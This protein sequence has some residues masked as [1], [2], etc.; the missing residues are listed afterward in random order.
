MCVSDADG[1]ESAGWHRLLLPASGAKEVIELPFPAAGIRDHVDPLRRSLSRPEG[2]HH[3]LQRRRKAILLVGA[4]RPGPQCAG[5]GILVD[6]HEILVVGRLPDHRQ[7]EA[8]SVDGR[9]LTGFLIRHDTQG[10]A[11]LHVVN[12]AVPEFHRWR[13]SGLGVHCRRRHDGERGRNAHDCH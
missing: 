10:E 12:P 9:D 5:R 11:G 4:R 13:W 3:S 2:E 1:I 6:P 7:P 8:P